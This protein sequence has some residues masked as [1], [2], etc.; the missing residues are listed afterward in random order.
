MKMSD[1][2]A[3]PVSIEKIHLDDNQIAARRTCK[4]VSH[5]VNSHDALVE[6]LAAIHEFNKTIGKNMFGIFDY[7]PYCDQANSHD[8]DCILNASINLL[9][10]I[11]G[12]SNG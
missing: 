11:N 12:E 8:D 10:K 3:S 1:Y 2:F 7:C 9:D 5:A 4:A 6:A